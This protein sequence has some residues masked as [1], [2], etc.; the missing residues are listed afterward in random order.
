MISPDDDYDHH[1]AGQEA[2]QTWKRSQAQGPLAGPSVSGP[3]CPAA[4][5]FR[6][7]T[8]PGGA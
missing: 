8:R 6:P 7:E 2:E 3:S 1:G 4:C 5:P